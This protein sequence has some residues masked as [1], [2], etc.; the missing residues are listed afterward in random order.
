MAGKPLRGQLRQMRSLRVGAYRVLY[1]FVA[2][3]K[4]VFV[5]TVRHRSEAYRDAR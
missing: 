4:T 1:R 3:S 2:P 5:E